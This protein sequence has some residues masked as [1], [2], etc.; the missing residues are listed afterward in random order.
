MKRSPLITLLAGAA[1]AIGLWIAS[2]VAASPAPAG[3]GTPAAGAAT[4]A[5]ASSASSSPAIVAAGTEVPAVPSPSACAAACFVSPA[6]A[7]V[8]G[9]VMG[10]G[11]AAAIVVHDTTAIA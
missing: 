3:Y 6:H 8:G 1:L 10:G 2:M 11:G 9:P 5:P 7:S 4:T